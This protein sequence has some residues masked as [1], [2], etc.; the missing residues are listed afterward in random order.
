MKPLL[1]AVFLTPLALAQDPFPN[2]RDRSDPVRAGLVDA[3]GKNA[4]DIT[5]A[6]LVKIT[7]LKLPHIHL[8]SFKDQDFIG[9]TN[10]KKLHFF[11]LLH[12]R[13]RTTDPI[14]IGPKVFLPLANLEELILQ[15]QLG[16][17][18]DDVFAGLTNLRI[19]DMTSAT[20]NRLPKSL[21]TLPKI[22]M[23]YFTGHG[24]PAADYATLKEKLGPKLQQRR[25]K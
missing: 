21:L 2:V 23:V 10:L 14:A 22:E 7:N 1:L 11:S 20:L 18:P 9:L 16:L 17:L 13:G 25:A 3:L 19:L 5:S 6:D 4:G 12:N 15:E 24:M 8:Q